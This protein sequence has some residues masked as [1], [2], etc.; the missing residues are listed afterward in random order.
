[1]EGQMIAQLKKSRPRIN[2][3]ID[4]FLVWVWFLILPV[5]VFWPASFWY[6]LNSV[7][8][9]NLFTPEGRRVLIVDRSINNQFFGMWRVEEQKQMPDGHFT[10]V[11]VCKG[12]SNYMRDKA[13]PH[14]IT[15]DWWKGDDCEFIHPFESLDS[16]TYR[17]CTFV[18][19][20]PK[21]MP[22]ST[23]Q[24]CSNNFLR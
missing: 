20:V 22:R 14:P 6:S 10:T 21:F 1:M 11:Q 15:L 24:N 9:T 17:L 19:V 23:V 4:H 3:I 2:S 13:M 7:E 12:E 18:T 8:V 16:G 5:M